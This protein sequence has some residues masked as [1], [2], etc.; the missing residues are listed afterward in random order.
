MRAELSQGMARSSGSGRQAEL[1]TVGLGLVGD[2]GSVNLLIDALDH[3]PPGAA[4]RPPP[5]RSGRIGA[6]DR[7]PRSRSTRSTCPTSC[8]LAAAGALGDIG[9]P[10]AAAGLGLAARPRPP[11]T[12]APLA[13]S[14]LRLGEPGMA[15][16]GP[17]RRRTPPRRWPCTRARQGLT[18]TGVNVF[19]GLIMAFG[20]FFI[21]YSLLINTSFLLL[22][23]LA[24]ADFIGYRRRVDFAAYDESFA[25]P[26]APRHL[27]ADAR[28]QRER[29]HRGVGAGDD[30][31]CATPTSRSSSSTTA[32]RTTRRQQLVDAFDMVEVPIVVPADI[33]DDRA[34]DRD[35]PQPRGQPQRGPG[36]ASPTAARPTRSTSGINAGPQAAGLHGRRG[37]AARPRRAAARLPPVRR[38]PRPGGRGRRRRPGRQ[39]LARSREGRVTDVRMPR[40]WLAADPGGRVP[41]RVHDRPRR[42]VRDSAGC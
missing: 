1:A 23:V 11:M 4:G 41:P 39:R 30:G 33:A 36:H 12:S 14:L 6:P 18:W 16:C 35:L 2:V 40:R 13:A 31:A 29:R 22:T 38:R 10:R 25:E 3:A 19:S 34:R 24:V 28:L 5:R 32:P 15:R 27:G 7:D 26:L 9:D 21:G 8:P 20:W 17:T 37:L 42:L